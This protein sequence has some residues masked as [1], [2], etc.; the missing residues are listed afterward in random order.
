MG[1]FSWR[2]AEVH[3][4]LQKVGLNL[5][6]NSSHLKSLFRITELQHF[7][8]PVMSCSL[9]NSNFT[10][11]PAAERLCWWS[12]GRRKKKWG[13]GGAGAVQAHMQG[14]K[15]EQNLLVQLQVLFRTFDNTNKL[16]IG[17]F[18]E[19]LSV[20]DWILPEPKLFV[21]S[22]CLVILLLLLL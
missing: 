12:K 21:K 18:I 13:K 16:F 10:S 19:C 1:L 22:C 9:A 17:M 15:A 11:H 5:T 6:A 3:A 8:S 4:H 7:W 2:A 20:G 14:K